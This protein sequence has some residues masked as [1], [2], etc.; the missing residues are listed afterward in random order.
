MSLRLLS[1]SSIAWVLLAMVSQPAARCAEAETA[2]SQE[3]A[4]GVLR[5]HRVFVPADR[6]QDWPR[7]SGKYLPVEADEFERLLTLARGSTP[8]VRALRAAR[9][10]TAEYRARLEGDR[11][12]EGRATLQVVHSGEAAA[13]LPL[14]PCGLA[15]DQA[16]W[17][18]AE[19]TEDGS[20]DAVLGLG[21]DGKLKVLVSRSGRLHF[22]WSLGGS[23]E[24]DGTLSFPIAL[25]ACPTSRLILELPEDL[26]VASDRGLAQQEGQAEGGIQLWRVELGG[27]YRFRLRIAP[28]ESAARRPQSASVRE[29]VVYDFSP[30]GVDVTS[31]LSI[32]SPERP[33]AQVALTLEDELQ[34]VGAAYGD[35]PASWSPAPDSGGRGHRVI[36]TLPEPI[37]EAGRVL[38]LQALAPLRTDGRWRLPKIVPEDLFWREGNVTLLVPAP[39]LLQE[40]R[41]V[42]CRQSGAAALSGTRE[43][44]SVEFRCFAADATVEVLLARRE[45]TVRL[46][47]G[48]AVRLG[49]REM[50]AEVR[51]DFRVT[52][53]KRFSL[54]A[55]VAPRWL[56]DSVESVPAEAMDDWLLDRRGDRQRLT[57]RLAKPLSPSRT[58]LVI[59]AQRLH[60]PW[61]RESGVNCEDLVPLRFDAPQQ[62]KQLLAVDAVSPFRLRLIDGDQLPRIAPQ[63]LDAAE[64]DLF[65]QLPGELLTLND[66]SAAGL[67]VSLESQKPTYGGELRV[68]AGV[69]DGFFRENY[70]L[71]CLPKSARVDRVLVHFSHRREVPPRFTLGA[72][73]Q[74]QLS[75]RPLSIDE[76]AAAGLAPEGETW[77]L[78]LNR[79]RSQ[80]FELRAVRESEL[81]ARQPVSL[82]WLPEAAEQRGTLVVRSLGSQTVRV[83]NR[84]LER[85]SAEI[86]T[87]ERRQTVRAVFRYD[88]TRDAVASPDATVVSSSS[89]SVAPPAWAWAC[90][91][92]SRYGS[93]AA[94]EH[95]ATYFLQSCRGNRIRLRLPPPAGLQDLHGAWIDGKRA[96]RREE[97]GNLAI[98]LPPGEKFPRVTVHFTTPG[99]GLGIGGS[100]EPPFPTL[101]DDV[102]VFSQRWT[103]WLPPGYEAV[104]PNLCPQ[105]PPLSSLSWSQRLFGPLG[106]SGEAASFDPF[107]PEHWSSRASQRRAQHL[108]QRK[109]ERLLQTL[110]ALIA[111]GAAGPEG[112]GLDW[113]RLLASESVHVPEVSL[114]VDRRAMAQ[115]AL[116]PQTPVR[117]GGGDAPSS[118]GIG[119]LHQA[120]LALLV[121]PDAML[122][123]SQ[124]YAGMLRGHLAPLQREVLWWVNPGQLADRMREAA[125]AAPWEAMVPVAAWRQEPADPKVP[126]TGDA[127]AGCQPTDSYAW[128]AY[129][130]EASGTAPLRLE[131]VHRPTVR[132]F[133]V[134]AF[135]LILAVAWWKL[136]DRPLSLLALTGAFGMA[137]LVLPDTYAPIASAGVLAAL[138]CLT[139]RLI[140]RQP[141]KPQPAH[142]TSGGNSEDA[143]NSATA[144]PLGIVMLAVLASC[145]WC[146]SA[147]GQESRQELPATGPSA[148]APVHRVFIPIDDAKQPAG[149]KYYV[150]E[151]LY[152]QLHRRA[153]AAAV[154]PQGFLLRSAT[155]RGA[156]SKQ[157]ASGG[158]VVDPLK[159]TFQLQ[160]FGTV[161]RIPLPFLGKEAVLLPDGALLD[162][163]VIQPQW[164]PDGSVL[165]LEVPE[166]GNY[167]L[168]LSVR[169]MA[170][171][172]QEP[173]GIDLAIPRLA[174]SRLELALPPDAS[175]VE[176]PSAVGM[177]RIEKQP[178]K[179]V[180]ELGPT[181]RLTV[182][183]PGGAGVAPSGSAADVE[184]LLWLKVQP[185]SVSV[186]ARFKFK[187][188]AGQIRELQLATDPALQILPLAGDDPPTVQTRAAPGRRQIISLEWPRAVSKSVVVDATFKLKGTSGVGHLRLPEVRALGTRSTRRW[189][190]VSV[191]PELVHEAPAAGRF[192]AVAV[193]DFL[194][195]WGNASSQPLLAYRLGPGE[196]D[197]ALRTELCEPQIAG[198]HQLACSFER[199]S[200]ELRLEA[201]LTPKAG[202]IFQ[203]RLKAP[204]GMQIEHVSAMEEGAER[205]ARWSQDPDGSITV[206]LKGLMTGPQRLLLRA[207][208]PIRDGQTPLELPLVQIE[209]LSAQSSEVRLYRRPSVRLEIGEVQGMVAVE[210]PAGQPIVPD[211]GRAAARFRADGGQPGKITLSVLPNQPQTRTDQITRL[212]CH[213]GSWDAEV[214]FRIRVTDGLLDTIPIEVSSLFG[215]PYRVQA[216]PSA[217]CEVLDAPGQPR[218]LI[219]RP[220]SAIGDEYRFTLISSLALTPSDRPRAPQVEPR[221]PGPLTRLLC[222][223]TH[224]QDQ[225]AS[226]EIRG[227]EKTTPPDNL[228]KSPLES[229]TAYRIVGEPWRA[230]L[231]LQSDSD[232]AARV[233][234]ADVHVAWKTDG[235]CHGVTAFDLEPG[236]ATDCR[237]R[238]PLGYD[239]VHVSVA[240]VPTTPVRIDPESWQLP[241]GPQQLPQRVEI[242][243]RGALSGPLRSATRRFETPVLEGLPAE[244]TLWTV[245]GPGQ[246]TPDEVQGIG[247]ASSWHQAWA[248]LRNAAAMIESAAAVSAEAPE[249]TF[250]WYWRWA[251]RLAAA[252][253]EL[254]QRLSEAG[255]SKR[256]Q[257]VRL[258]ARVID[259]RQAQ[260]AEEL[261]M[262]DAF[263]QLSGDL[264]AECPAELWSWS[265]DC[266]QVTARYAF[267]QDVPSLTLTYHP[268]KAGRLRG[269]L[270][271]ATGLLAA[272]ALALF[273]LRR[274]VWSEAFKRWPAAFGVGLGLAW[275]LWLSPSL[276]GWAIVAASLIASLLS[277][278]RRSRPTMGSSIVAVRTMQR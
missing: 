204:P 208:L 13:L 142:D 118:R 164:Q 146:A 234:L 104:D 217:I 271:A 99:A 278:W 85:I 193:P 131:F 176:V 149:D 78:T 160:V 113:G 141:G 1:V 194:S 64:R 133:A 189:L 10:I 272:V 94:G 233:R 179:I 153:A 240:G 59:R 134:S 18:D 273:G 161:A 158:M 31:E 260:I 151:V 265:L 238:L 270:L 128:T 222:L 100:L 108:A 14:D 111:K 154:Q 192:E 97:G 162:G 112:S 227:L 267:P 214:D 53:G 56:I 244:E 243:F 231:R 17:F 73:D 245:L 127:P 226:W 258:E 230:V 239:L 15:V 137:S 9:T 114:L 102:P 177:V 66:A 49:D 77:E 106:R 22:R 96:V 171:G 139:C 36:V 79:S 138:F 35:R 269:G 157:A 117:P 130:L 83:V 275:W 148:P 87:P 228:E 186:S 276:F 24:I 223:P 75:A 277:G 198:R 135:L 51:A 39:L 103:V 167:R 68:E 48:T 105:T 6:I 219:V 126:W 172:G 264:I 251:R 210:D 65:A 129:R 80:P 115:L 119:L 224:S 122:L 27:H 159:A 178:P 242:V 182:H 58:L 21:A 123:T 23:R 212:L 62:S 191:D 262:A 44:E 52:D 253:A 211:L 57:V 255:N 263:A 67:R 120:G 3:P 143:G 218:R 89:D 232:G 168:E 202:Y 246:W 38:R 163:R 256:V 140:R 136:P 181:D 274:G 147:G 54:Q 8:D 150:P 180:A 184:E 121:H 170:R 116:T 37:Q 28:T 12:T 26:T 47:S 125:A 5:F 221:L 76:Q 60:T 82:A 259:Q 43:G 19:D 4:S 16:T 92:Q 61:S 185:G 261:G 50:T 124:A 188:I 132:L 29:T 30:R 237:L 195:A 152:E 40:A 7:G 91:L 88:P 225:P 183:W 248:R 235:S 187:I 46:A 42:K 144:A 71:R 2:P 215:G 32:G 70:T 45:A 34:L 20:P 72:E 166:P 257:D 33:L 107:S 55:D 175:G 250:R 203:H 229:F 200:V 220:Q 25:P 93:D 207:R 69:G 145:V 86:V 252:R 254:T 174:T 81:S 98:D 268:E 63:S 201:E 206:F 173:A 90:R 247:P 156:L 11:L 101:L 84:R 155:Y 196:I 249:E 74:R 216:D 205:A 197:W 190:A 209:R 169:P 95:L 41:P 110:G 236:K 165:V 213:G 266:R 109:A 241:L 199:G